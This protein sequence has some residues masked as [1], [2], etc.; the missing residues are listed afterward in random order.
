MVGTEH[1]GLILEHPCYATASLSCL[2]IISRASFCLTLPVFP[3][4]PL[5]QHHHFWS[6]LPPQHQHFWSILLPHP[7]ISGAS[8]VSA[9]LF[10]EHPPHSF[11]ASLQLCPHW[12]SWLQPLQ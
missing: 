2:G 3:E 12:S 6:I 5:P 4:H 10:L 1:S 8:S 9:S 7:N 11:S